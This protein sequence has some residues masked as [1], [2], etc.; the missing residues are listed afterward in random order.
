MFACIFAYFISFHFRISR[1]RWLR[2]D[3]FYEMYF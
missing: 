3:E 2:R 1:T